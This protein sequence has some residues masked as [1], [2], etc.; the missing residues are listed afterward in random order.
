MDYFFS[1]IYCIFIL[2]SL[3]YISLIHNSGSK[4]NDYFLNTNTNENSNNDENNKYF[5]NKRRLSSSTKN[6][7]NESLL[8]ISLKYQNY[9]HKKKI[10]NLWNTQL[11]EKFFDGEVNYTNYTYIYNQK[12]NTGI[13]QLRIFIPN[14]KKIWEDENPTFKIRIKENKTIDK[15]IFI[16]KY[17]KLRSFLDLYDEMKEV[18]ENITMHYYNETFL[19]M[20]YISKLE[21][22]EYF[23]VPYNRKICNIIYTIN[24]FIIL[25]I[26]L[27]NL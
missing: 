16:S 12:N 2:L 14:E 27:I 26:G 19:N 21:K 8:N 22:G 9:F 20:S 17:I 7:T 5:S 3:F 13:M 1:L 15:W 10:L 11:K 18:N 4:E 24:T 6:E 23:N 25:N